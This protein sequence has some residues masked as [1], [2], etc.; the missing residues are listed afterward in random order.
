MES[1]MSDR[2]TSSEMDLGLLDSDF[3]RADIEFHEVDHSGASFEA[4]IFLNNP[5]ADDQTELTPETGYAGSFHIF[6]HGGCFGDDEEH[7]VA[8]PRSPYD[9]RPAHPLSRARKVVIATEAIRRAR[10]YGTTVTITVVPIITS[11]TDKSSRHNVLQFEKIV[12]VSYR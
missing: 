1:I 5:E 2:Y 10:E 11:M 6:G 9:P 12:I 8:T 7:C 3:S 4:R